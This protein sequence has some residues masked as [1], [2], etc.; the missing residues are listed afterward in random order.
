MNQPINLD[1][2]NAEIRTQ[3]TPLPDELPFSVLEMKILRML[4]DGIGREI[5]RLKLCVSPNT[6]TQ[7]KVKLFLEYPGFKTYPVFTS[8]T[9]ISA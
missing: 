6:I 2:L 4:F 3:E 1:S 9:E 8:N 7:T 5:I